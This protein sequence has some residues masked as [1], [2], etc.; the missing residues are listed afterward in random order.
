MTD[1]P[2]YEDAVLSSDIP[3]SRDMLS[4]L[5]L[6]SR[7]GKTFR[8]IL[9]SY[10]AIPGLVLRMTEFYTYALS[11]SSIRESWA[12][13]HLSIGYR[14]SCDPE[15]THPHTLHP[16]AAFVDVYAPHDPVSPLN[17]ATVTILS[18]YKM[19]FN[20]APFPPSMRAYMSSEGGKAYSSLRVFG[21][22]TYRELT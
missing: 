16:H 9:P 7:R 1:F 21:Y 22:R 17:L 18:Y 15:G 10:P 20:G 19:P 2:F 8:Y 6:L 12:P 5:L 3:A 14:T 4:E 13:T 11:G